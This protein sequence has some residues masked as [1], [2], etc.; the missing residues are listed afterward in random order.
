MSLGKENVFAMHGSINIFV[1][2][3]LE[4]SWQIPE[5]RLAS[6]QAFG[7]PAIKAHII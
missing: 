4:L 1:L 6:E 7:N 2:A 3:P 5:C